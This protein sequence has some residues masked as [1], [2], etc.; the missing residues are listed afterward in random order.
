MTDSD[1]LIIEPLEKRHDRTAFSCGLPELDHYLARQAGQDVRRRT[2][3][4]FVCT[5]VDTDAVLGFYTLNALSIGLASLPERLSRKLPRHPVPCAF[6]SIIVNSVF[7]MTWT[8]SWIFSS[9]RKYLSGPG[10]GCLL[11]DSKPTMRP[12]PR[13]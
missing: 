1:A 13:T 2:A 9:P 10:R 11:E 6:H 12:M 7:S 3:R 4:V 8:M 5:A